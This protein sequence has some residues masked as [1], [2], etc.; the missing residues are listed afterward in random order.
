MRSPSCRPSPAA[1]LTRSD[2]QVA[3]AA[4]L[5][6]G[7][8]AL[9]RLG[10]DLEVEVKSAEPTDV[11]T[12]ADR[13]AEGAAVATIV[14]ARPH[15][16]ISGEE[17][18]DRPAQPGNARRWIVDAID[19]TLNFS[20]G[21]PS[22][23]AAV[24]LV[25]DT[26]PPT[27]VA[28]AVYDPERDELFSAARGRG[29]HCGGAALRVRGAV[30]LDRAAVSC[31]WGF[32][33]LGAAGVPEVAHRIV[34]HVGALRIPGSGTLELAWVAAGR[35]HGWLQPDAKPWDWLPGALLVAEAGGVA[36]TT[37]DGRWSLAGSAELVA[38]MRR[39][40]LAG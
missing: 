36:L 32:G 10:A 15:D 25:E 4:A 16:A 30:P 28:S 40:L 5:A 21:L 13:E 17:G 14:R 33:K 22:W 35:L 18:T 38:A 26:T 27:P 8:A 20:L 7:Q 6:A 34:D 29:T 23:C 19:G 39:E 3:E 9:R 37:D 11:V 31:H 1:E 24:V 12:V 2:L